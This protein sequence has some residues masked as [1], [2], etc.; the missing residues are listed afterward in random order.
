MPENSESAELAG[1]VEVSEDEIPP[2]DDENSE[3]VFFK[4]RKN[5]QLFQKEEKF[6]KN[7]CRKNIL[8][9]CE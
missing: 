9:F 7:G 1:A 4:F 8:P 5:N 3:Y 2:T 6:I